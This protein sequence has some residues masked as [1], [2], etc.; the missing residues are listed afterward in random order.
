M[1]ATRRAINQIHY[2]FDSDGLKLEKSDDIKLHCVDFFSE[3]FGGAPHVLSSDDSDLIKALTPFKCDEATKVGLTA[4]ISMAEI[5]REVFALPRNRAPGPDGFTG[6]SWDIIGDDLSRAVKEFFSSGQILK[7][8][9]ATAI[10]LVP[11]IESAGFDRSCISPR[12]LL[13]VDLRKAFDSVSWGF[14]SQVLEA[15]DFPPI[16]TNWILQCLTT[17]SFSINVNGE[18]CGYFKG[19]RGL[20]QGDPLSPPL[21]LLAMEIFANLL[22]TKYEEGAIGYHPLG[23]NPQI[24]HLAFADDVMLFFDGKVSSLEAITSTLD[25][26]QVLS[27]LRMNKEKTSLFLAAFALP[28]NCLKEIE[29]L[30][31]RFLWSGDLSKST[32]AKVLNLRL[33]WLLFSNAGSLWVAWTKEHYFKR[34]GFWSPDGHS[35]ASWICKFLLG[36]RPMAKVLISCNIGNGRLASFW[37]DNWSPLGILWDIFGRTGP[38]RL[39]IPLDSTVVDACGDFGWNLPSARSR[40]LNVIDLRNQLL[41]TAPPCPSRGPDCYSWGLAN[42]KKSYFST[43]YT[44]NFFRPSQDKKYW[45][46]AVWFKNSVPKQAFTFWIATLDR[47]PV[48]VRL[49]DWGLNTS[50]LCC[51]CNSHDESRD[52]LLLHCTFSEQVWVLVLHRLGLPPCTFV[53]WCTVIS[54]LLTKSPYVST[55]LKRICTQATV[56]LIWRE[57]NNRL[58][59]AVSSSVSVVFGQIDRNIKDTLLAR[60]YRKGCGRLL[61]QWFAHS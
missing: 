33:V 20:R 9:N 18:L 43:K 51:F 25:K 37:F 45:Y 47:L 14:I 28:K 12:G 22:S 58:H 2:L 24:S 39:G 27:G 59:N 40:S 1:M 48:R 38:S 13:K 23:R 30:C 61:S 5:K 52:H 15:A 57:R 17:T 50:S 31:N 19:R 44:W 56:Y 11:K 54:W 55:T 10:T 4:D 53:D 7:Q 29:K 21:F 8:W 6:A 32:A 49:A 46:P 26:F 34:Y 35:N 16:F 36:L 41:A 42:Q 60:R 3:L